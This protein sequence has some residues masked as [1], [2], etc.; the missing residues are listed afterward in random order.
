[1]DGGNSFEIL[2]ALFSH[3]VKKTSHSFY[4][5]DIVYIGEDGTIYMTK[6]GEGFFVWWCFFVLHV[7]QKSKLSGK[8]VVL[9]G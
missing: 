3:Y 8:H 5:S 4:T 7:G 2:C 6:A 9:I 1:M